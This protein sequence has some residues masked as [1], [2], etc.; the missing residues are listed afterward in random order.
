[1]HGDANMG[2]IVLPF[3]WGRK[4]AGGERGPLGGW[5]AFK[6]ITK[7]PR[8]TSD[9]NALIGNVPLNE[10]LLTTPN[11][12]LL[13]VLIMLEKMKTRMAIQRWD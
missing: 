3:W 12:S 9:P 7:D 10:V 11:T 13:N 2:T 5:T 4:E 8:E 6:S 1:M